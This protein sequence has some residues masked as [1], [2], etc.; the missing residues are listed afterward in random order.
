MHI[1]EFSWQELRFWTSF[2]LLSQGVRSQDS[3]NLFFQQAIF[4][5]HVERLVILA[6]RHYCP[7]KHLYEENREKMHVQIF[8][9]GLSCSL[10]LLCPFFQHNNAW[11]ARALKGSFSM[12]GLSIWSGSLSAVATQV[13]GGLG[14]FLIQLVTSDLLKEDERY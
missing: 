2:F 7:S 12:A 4:L 1:W 13:K 10:H 9:N 3:S 14:E 11:Q 8:F 5:S 6:W